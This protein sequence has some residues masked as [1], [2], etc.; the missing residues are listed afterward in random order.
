MHT[1]PTIFTFR[2]EKILLF[3]TVTHVPYTQAE[4][5]RIQKEV[6]VV[7]LARIKMRKNERKSL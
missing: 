6:E 4:T 5:K 2:T 7:R 1:K 3:V